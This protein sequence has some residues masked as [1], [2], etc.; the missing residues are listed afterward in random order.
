MSQ[1][2]GENDTDPAVPGKMRRQATSSADWIAAAAGEHTLD[3]SPPGVQRVYALIGFYVTW[4][5]R[6][7]WSHKRLLAH[8]IAL[9][10]GATALSHHLWHWMK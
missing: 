7:T 3:S 4:I 9:T 10:F 8:W 6:E 5:L 2:G 1:N